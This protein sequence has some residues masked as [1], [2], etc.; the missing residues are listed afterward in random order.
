MALNLPA[1]SDELREAFYE[2]S[3][4]QDVPDAKL[5]D[6]LVRRYP[7]LGDELTE[8]AIA[9]ALDA[10]RG[11]RAVEAAQAAMP[12]AVSPGVSRALSHFQHQLHVTGKGA[13]GQQAETAQKG[14]VANPFSKLPTDEFKGLA[15][16]LNVSSIFVMKLRDRQIDPQTIPARFEQRVAEELSVPLELI[17]AHFAARPALQ[18]GQYFKAEGKPAVGAQQSFEQAVRSSGMSAEQQKGLLDM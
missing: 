10:L 12:A 3:V 15:A 6:E 18:A 16:R 11:D 17:H 8:L 13:T 14:P 1:E 2:L 4:A 7:Q 9:I 5:L